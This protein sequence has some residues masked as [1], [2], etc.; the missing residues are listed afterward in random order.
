MIVL[1]LPCAAKNRSSYIKLFFIHSFKSLT[2]SNKLVVASLMSCMSMDTPVTRKVTLSMFSLVFLGLKTSF[3]TTQRNYHFL[4][5]STYSF[6]KMFFVDQNLR[7]L[8]VI[9]GFTGHGN[10][11]KSWISNLV[12]VGQEILE[13]TS[14]GKFWKIS[15]MQKQKILVSSFAKGK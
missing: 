9:Q 5:V 14:H 8:K 4:S 3:T 2:F 13:K 11:G 10:P 12:N 7:D 6:F 15:S 1:N